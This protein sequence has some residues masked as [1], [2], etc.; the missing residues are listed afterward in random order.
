MDA[1]VVI[2]GGLRKSRL[3]ASRQRHGLMAAGALAIAVCFAACGEEDPVIPSPEPE[4]PKTLLVVPDD[5]GTI[6]AA[7]LEA[8]AGDTV[9][10]RG[11]TYAETGLVIAAGVRLTGQAGAAVVI[12]ATEIT[13]PHNVL[14]LD[15]GTD[16]SQP[17]IVTNLTIKAGSGTAMWIDSG[18]GTVIRNC[19]ILDSHNG[20]LL[21]STLRMSSISV[22][23]C[24]FERNGAPLDHSGSEGPNAFVMTGLFRCTLL[25]CTFRDNVGD[26]AGALRCDAR[27]GTLEIL[28]CMFVGNRA[29]GMG[30]AIEVPHADFVRVRDCVFD[31]NSSSA[32]GAIG[33]RGA[34]YAVIEDSEFKNN[35]A[36]QGGAVYLASTHPTEVQ[37]CRFSGNI[38]DYGGAMN[39]RGGEYTVSNCFF[40]GN[41]GAD[42]D[43]GVP[44]STGGAIHAGPSTLLTVRRSTFSGNWAY[45]LP[46]DSEGGACL[47]FSGPIG[48]L[49]LEGCILSFSPVGTP[50][51]GTPPIMRIRTNDAYGNASGDWVGLLEPF[52]GVDENISADPL[53]CSIADDDLRLQ[54]GSACIGF[55]NLVIMGA[56]E[57]GCD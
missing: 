23:S 55:P 4:P 6:K 47:Y 27:L 21:Y 52:A 51:A 49:D 15:G 19:R 3:V 30:G 7:L 12:D 28:R 44:S 37:N 22:D 10:V 31:G 1:H 5:Y 13:S 53:F 29:R 57:A 24:I 42:D 38:A 33:M 9:F 16:A 36:T 46:F 32:G 54:F 41:G 17:S 35:A 18:V 39:I 8:D 2:L 48:S 56:G 43:P 11:G 20:I 40:I 26:Q 25:D 45:G 14:F 50:L 34:D